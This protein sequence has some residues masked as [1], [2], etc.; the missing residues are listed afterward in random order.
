[1]S[2]V[3]WTQEINFGSA[4]L[5]HSCITVFLKEISNG[6]AIL[7][8][9]AVRH[10]D[11][12][13]IKTSVVLDGYTSV[14][15]R[16]RDGELAELYFTNTGFILLIV[17][18]ACAIAMN[19]LLPATALNILIATTFGLTFIASAL[20]ACRERSLVM[21]IMALRRAGRFIWS[22]TPLV[23]F[24]TL[25][26]V[27]VVLKGSSSKL[28]LRDYVVFRSIAI[29][30]LVFMKAKIAAASVDIQRTMLD[31]LLHS[32]YVMIRSVSSRYFVYFQHERISLIPT[33]NLPSPTHRTAAAQP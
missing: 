31:R 27:A 13:G 5:L 28:A 26:Y 4:L 16:D 11:K 9:L 22:D 19:L 3:P 30:E 21:P 2:P 25:I 8:H 29:L 7:Y 14:F 17:S 6:F 32:E 18:L 20:V 15:S 1:M 10:R 24:F 33:E 23:N 12:A